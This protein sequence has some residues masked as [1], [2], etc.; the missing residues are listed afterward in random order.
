MRLVDDMTEL[1]TPE[2]KLYPATCIDLATPEGV[3]RAMA[4]HHRAGLPAAALRM[5]A[6]RGGLEHGCIMYTDRGSEYMSDEFRT[7]IG[8][9]RRRQPME[10]VGSCY[11]N[12]AA[13][14][15]PAA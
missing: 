13:E 3:G 4:D 1:T 9:L 10:R 15:A 7:G 8:K 12:A 2:G 11:D 6:G 14:L 5:A